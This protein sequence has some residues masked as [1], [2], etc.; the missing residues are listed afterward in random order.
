MTQ[1]ILF[2]CTHNSARSQMAQGLLNWLAPDRYTALSAG[3]H[4][5]GIHPLTVQ[6]MAELGI[7]I[8][9]Q[10]SHSLSAY[11]GQPFDVVVTVCD[12]AAEQLHWGFAD[13][14]SVQ[15]DEAAQMAAFRHTR[16]LILVRLRRWLGQTAPA[17]VVPPTTETTVDAEHVRILMV[18]TGNSA[19]SQMGEAWLRYLGGAR[20]EVASAGT[21]PSRVHP[22]AIAVMDERGIDLRGHRS[23]SV[24]EFLH[25][26]FDYVITVCDQAA[27]QCPTFPGPAQREHWSFP[28]PAAVEGSPLDQLR[29]FRAVRDALYF[30]CWS[31]L[32]QHATLREV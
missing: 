13:P 16:D 3:I 5:T 15:G 10:G 9:G 7:D 25:H 26:P 8:T 32:A 11:Q 22:L 2:L 14:T 18:C 28:D 29:A 31:W 1:R 19:R 20:Y 17:E 24:N 21:H 6:V 12:S 4:P 23:K 30:A 27:E